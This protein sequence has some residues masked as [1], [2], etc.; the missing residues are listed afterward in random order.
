MKIE[1]LPSLEDKKMQTRF[2]PHYTMHRILPPWRC[3]ENIEE[4]GR[5]VGQKHNTNI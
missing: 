3:E 5:E 4:I 2:W 1:K